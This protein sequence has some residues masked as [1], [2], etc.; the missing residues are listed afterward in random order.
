MMMMMITPQSLSKS[1]SYTH[2]LNFEP[3]RTTNIHSPI[4][5][6]SFHSPSQL[7]SRFDAD[8]TRTSAVCFA[9]APIADHA[10]PCRKSV[11]V[12]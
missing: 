11:V 10:P 5:S 4:N 7:L 12:P 2:T 6:T 9:L 8:P 3:S 1:F